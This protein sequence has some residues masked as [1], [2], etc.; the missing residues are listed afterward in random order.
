VKLAWIMYGAPAV[1]LVVM[2]AA[3]SPALAEPPANDSRA[4]A[5]VLSPPGGVNG[6]TAESTLEAGEAPA[7]LTQGSRSTAALGRSCPWSRA[8]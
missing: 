3:A 1:A 7:T 5:G 8:S 4:A 6:T 2:G